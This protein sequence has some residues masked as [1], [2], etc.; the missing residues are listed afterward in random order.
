MTQP[1]SPALPRA[2]HPGLPIDQLGVEIVICDAKGHPLRRR[3]MTLA[4]CLDL[5]LGRG[6][7]PQA[8]CDSAPY[9]AGTPA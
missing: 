6:L 3:M 2:P 5:D 9:P 4:S 1:L 7:G 8:A